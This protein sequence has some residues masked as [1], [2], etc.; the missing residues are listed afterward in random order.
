M[1]K[2][3]VANGLLISYQDFGGSGESIVFLHGWRSSKEIWD[4]IIKR[5]PSGKYRA[6]SLDF[7]GFGKSPLPEKSMSVGDYAAVA[8]ETIT[9]LSLGRVI[10]VGHSFGGRIGIK[11]AAT[12]PELVGKLILADSAGFA[13]PTGKKKLLN[14]LAKLVRPVF[15]L[16]A[17]AGLRRRIYKLIGAEDYIATPKLQQTFVQVT[18][19]DLTADM[20]KI[21]CPALIINGE[22]DRETPPVFGRR[23][24]A[25]IP[26]SI[27]RIIAKAGHFSFL[28]QPDEFLTMIGQFIDA[29]I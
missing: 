11:L 13:M 7:P 29:K 2:E 4:G 21:S 14:F 24:Q 10:I 25:L 5:L 28:D 9:K 20:Q 26:G 23:M 22:L 6:L 27:L 8:A 16:K 3:L 12:R 19:E 1:E 18:G 17:L 15:R